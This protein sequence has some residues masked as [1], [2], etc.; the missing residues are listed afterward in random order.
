MRK[1][2]CKEAFCMYLLPDANRWNFLLLFYFTTSKIDFKTE[3]YF[4]ACLPCVF[5]RLFLVFQF[6]MEIIILSPVVCYQFVDK[7]H[8][9]DFIL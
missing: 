1:P 4:N 5:L 7:M 8:M 3:S 6:I 2:H 9:L